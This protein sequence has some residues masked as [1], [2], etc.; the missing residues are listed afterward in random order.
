[1]K[2]DIVFGFQHMISMFGACILIPLL[3]G[4]DIPVALF[5]AG[6]GTLVFHLLTKGNIPIFLGSSGS[7]VAVIILINE[8]YGKSYSYGAIVSAG[9]IYMISALVVKL[10][11]HEKFLKVFPPLVVGPI[12]ML[13]GITLI[14]YTLNMTSDNWLIAIIT[15]V[16]MLIVGIYAK[17]FFKFLPIL[18]GIV[19][20]Y[21]S[22]AIMGV[23]DFKPVLEAAWFSLPGFSTPKFA[24]S[25][26]ILLAPIALVTVIEHIGEVGANG[27]IVGKNWFKKPGLHKTLFANGITISLAGFIGAPPNTTYGENNATLALT[28]QFKPSILRIAAVFAIV[29]AFIGKFSALITTIPSAVMGGVSFILFGTLICI[30]L[31]QLIDS[32]EDLHDMR[33]STIVLSTLI[34]GIS[35]ITANVITIKI[36][37]NLVFSGLSLAAIVAVVLNLIINV[38]FKKKE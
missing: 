15:I 37:E 33:N 8:M 10:I 5:M 18:T 35:S 11:G 6:L 34:V 20:G 4:F 17:G 29:L 16:T 7:F 12:V 1:M 31:Q 14:P 27:S 30:G 26:I 32:K 25:P 9:I 38:I 22:S 2:K 36:S 3:C 24:W 28:K 21:I 23:V 13:V 19:V